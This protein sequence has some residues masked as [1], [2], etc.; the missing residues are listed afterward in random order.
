MANSLRARAATSGASEAAPTLPSSCVT[1]RRAASSA[2]PPAFS[3]GA[4]GQRDLESVQ[5]AGLGMVD[6]SECSGQG[7]VWRVGLGVVDRLSAAGRA[8]SGEQG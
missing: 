7:S 1:A 4:H 2:P 8:Q 3:M 5:L 6:K